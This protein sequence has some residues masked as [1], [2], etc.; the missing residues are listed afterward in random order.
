MTDE[1]TQ[2][3]FGIALNLSVC[4]IVCMIVSRLFRL[5]VVR[6]LCD[7][8]DDHFCKID[9]MTERHTAEHMRVMEMCGSID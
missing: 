4:L 8:I 1:L 6:T 3:L 9:E 7:T 5:V 2:L